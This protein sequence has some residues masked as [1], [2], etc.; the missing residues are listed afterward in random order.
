[1]SEMEN[2]IRLRQFVKKVY[3]EVPKE[4]ANIT[5]SLIVGDSYD[6]ALE[7]LK[8]VTSGKNTRVTKTIGDAI[9]NRKLTETNFKYI[10]LT[11]Q[12]AELLYYLTR[13]TDAEVK[14]KVFAP[15]EINVAQKEHPKCDAVIKQMRCYEFITSNLTKLSYIK[16]NI[17]DDESIGIV[18]WEPQIEFIKSY[19]SCNLKFRAFKTESLGAL[20]GKD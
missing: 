17:P 7:M 11:M 12:G 15:E 16:K 3:D 14:S 6:F 13:L 2:N 18:C 10:P 9:N 8:S 5:D 1:M 19:L 20:F 4:M